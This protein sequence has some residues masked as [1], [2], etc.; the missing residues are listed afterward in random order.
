MDGKSRARC[1][2]YL[3]L[4]GTRKLPEYR[5]CD[6][7]G[8]LD[9]KR[10]HEHARRRCHVVGF[11]SARRLSI[12]LQCHTKLDLTLHEKISSRST[13]YET[14]KCGFEERFDEAGFL[15]FG[16]PASSHPSSLR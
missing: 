13:E 8:G 10:V 5:L 15:A 2:H 9:G 14:K 12:C 16:D 7:G 11:P 3:L 1:S 6:G 4:L